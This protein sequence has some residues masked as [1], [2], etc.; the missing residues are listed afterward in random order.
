MPARWESSIRKE[1]EMA[2]E[3]IRGSV[4]SHQ[5]LLTEISMHVIGSGGKRIRPGVV[6]LAFKAVGGT[7]TS[8]IISMAAS[9]ELIHSAT[10]IHDDI[11]DGGKMRRGSLSAFRKFG[12]QRALVAGDFLFVKGFQLG[13]PQDRQVVDY[14]ADACTHL[15]ESEILQGYHLR[16][17]RTPI[18]SY[19]KIIEGKTARPIEAGAKVGA[20]IGGG[21]SEQVEA[22]GSY[23]LNLGMAFQVTDDIL[24]IIGSEAAL[25]KPKGMDFL[26]GTPT[27]PLILAMNDGVDRRRISTLFTRKKK[28]SAEVGE[29]LH[30]LARSDA[31]ESAKEYAREFSEKAIQSLDP[32][33]PSPYKKSLQMLARAVIE[34]DS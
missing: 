14:L 3:A 20:F 22:L 23:G 28:T 7:G 21:T 17:P 11:N 5:G 16:D 29:A 27:L 8:K 9:F 4:L 15:A 18:D 12:I 6:I 31:I 1:L 13:G 30:L 19:L 10:L 25:G 2:E 32:I 26:D 34:R 24:D 33:A